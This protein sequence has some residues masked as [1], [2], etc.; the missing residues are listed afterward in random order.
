MKKHFFIAA[1]LAVLVVPN[2]GFGQNIVSTS[3]LITS[4]EITGGVQCDTGGPVPGAWVY[5][6]GDSFQ[7][8][9]DQQGRFRLR[10][11]PAGRYTVEIES[12]GVVRKTIG[13]VVV[14]KK[15]TTSLGDITVPCAAAACSNSTECA[16]GSYCGKSTGSC[17]GQGV[18]TA[19][20]EACPAVI[21]PVCGCDG[22]TYGNSC[23]AAMAG[24]SV[25]YSGAC[26]APPPPPAACG[27]NAQCPA[28]EY[29][30][31]LLGDCAG[32]GVCRPRPE[33]CVTLYDPVCGCNGTTYPSECDAAGSGVGV[34]YKGSCAVTP[35]PAAGCISN[36]EC[37]SAQYCAKA[38]GNCDGVGSC[39][40]RPELC[41]M[42]FAPVIGCDGQTYNNACEAAAAGVNVR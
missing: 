18:C 9:S 6:P 40:P 31:K 38:P 13:G 36:V 37:S 14:L 41:P 25:S 34:A 12:G 35:P 33:R 1:L 2:A 15:R 39:E 29:C 19:Q 27:D 5:V 24:V 21:D 3:G 16:A 22:R 11:V 30:V 32:A 42:F 4:G 28:S 26:I 7:S 10:T 8:R 20:P 23:E 17:A